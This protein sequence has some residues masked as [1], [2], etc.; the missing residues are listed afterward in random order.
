MRIANVRPRCSLPISSRTN[1]NFWT[2]VM[3]IFLARADESPQVTRMLR[4]ADDRSDLSELSN[5]VANL[6]VQDAAVG[7]DNYRT[8]DVFTCLLQ[9]DELMRQPRNRIAFS[10]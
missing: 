8:K 7:D 10:A 4:M 6:L 2:V 1:G 5:C 3:M 9:A